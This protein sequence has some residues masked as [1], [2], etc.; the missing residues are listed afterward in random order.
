MPSE[1]GSDTE[2]QQGA[3]WEH[4]SLAQVEYQQQKPWW[5]WNFWQLWQTIG[6]EIQPRQWLFGETNCQDIRSFLRIKIIRLM[7]FISLPKLVGF[8]KP[9]SRCPQS[10]VIATT[11]NLH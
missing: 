11:G 3:T 5:G 4:Q 6:L 1:D 8:V 9:Q 7:L 2:E 10:V